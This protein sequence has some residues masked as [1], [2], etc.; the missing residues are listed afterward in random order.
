MVGHDGTRRVRR[1]FAFLVQRWK[2]MG[3][4]ATRL[5]PSC[6]SRCSPYGTVGAGGPA[7]GGKEPRV[8]R[9]DT[10]YGSSVT[11]FPIRYAS[12]LR[13]ALR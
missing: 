1:R 6:L 8:E 9:Q 12:S 10:T 5:V 11:S 2:G 4:T 13:G 3:V 7:V